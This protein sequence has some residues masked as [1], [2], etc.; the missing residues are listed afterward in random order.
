MGYPGTGMAS[1]T[2]DI[3]VTCCLFR[4]SFDNCPPFI[5]G[6]S[7]GTNGGVCVS[8]FGKH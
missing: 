4:L 3:G 5:D 2:V 6:W 8:H 1:Q 7:E